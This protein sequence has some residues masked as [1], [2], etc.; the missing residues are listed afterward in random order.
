MGKSKCVFD[1][2]FKKTKYFNL[3]NINFDVLLQHGTC[4]LKSKH[5]KYYM[6]WSIRPYPLELPSMPGSPYPVLCEFTIFE[7]DNWGHHK[8]LDSF[9]GKFV[10]ELNSGTLPVLNGLGL[11]N[12]EFKSMCRDNNC[13]EYFK[14]KLSLIDDCMEMSIKH[15]TT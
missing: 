2:A 4:V 8:S 1:S 11:P 5:H 15:K 12:G 13:V 6:I 14:V 7:K 9:S 3:E 10:Y